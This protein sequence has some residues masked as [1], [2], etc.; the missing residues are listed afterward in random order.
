MNGTDAPAWAFQRKS[1]H[2]KKMYRSREA[3]RNRMLNHLSGPIDL[4]RYRPQL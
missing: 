2:D 4:G 1:V 3:D